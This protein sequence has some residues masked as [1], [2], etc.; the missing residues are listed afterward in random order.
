MVVTEPPEPAEPGSL[1]AWIL[2]AVSLLAVAAAGIWVARDRPV[3]TQALA[4]GEAAVAAQDA[5]TA[6]ASQVSAAAAGGAAPAGPGDGP[7]GAP[8]APAPAA[9]PGVDAADQLSAAAAAVATGRPTSRASGGRSALGCD[10][11]RVTSGPGGAWSG[12]AAGTDIRLEL[13]LSGTRVKGQVTE[14]RRGGTPLVTLT[15]GSWDAPSRVLTLRD[16]DSEDARDYELTLGTDDRLVGRY[17]ARNF[18]SEKRLSFTRD[19]REP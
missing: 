13:C 5:V 4:A 1:W 8:G 9:A 2:G 11:S 19:T 14:V 10:P 6:A 17:R 16:P 12:N 3:R 7:P 15:S 18:Q